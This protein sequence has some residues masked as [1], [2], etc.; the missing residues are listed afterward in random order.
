M[1][2]DITYQL[3]FGQ[4]P[5]HGIS[6]GWNWQYPAVPVTVAVPDIGTNTK[7]VNITSHNNPATKGQTTNVIQSNG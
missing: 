3:G 4:Y 2:S 5:Y 6:I 1:F 7:T